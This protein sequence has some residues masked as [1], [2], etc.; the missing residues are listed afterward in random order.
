M[1]IMPETCD[2]LPI[3]ASTTRF[4]H[5]D[6]QQMHNALLATWRTA[7]CE[8]LQLPINI[9]SPIVPLPSGPIVIRLYL[10]KYW[11][12]IVAQTLAITINR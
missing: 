5:C 10:P 11:R 4:S 7:A 6:R 3:S 1:P 9:A 8:S 12:S 2:D